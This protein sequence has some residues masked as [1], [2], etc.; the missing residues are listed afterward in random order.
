[1]ASADRVP[2]T[3][4]FAQTFSS[5]LATRLNDTVSMLTYLCSLSS[6]SISPL[7]ELDTVGRGARETEDRRG[8]QFLSPLKQKQ[9][10][11]TFVF[12]PCLCSNQLR[13]VSSSRDERL[14]L[15]FIDGNILKGNLPPA[16]TV[17]VRPS[18]FA[19]SRLYCDYGV[20]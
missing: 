19:C 20:S 12:S 14:Y 16:S 13:G 17:N 11:A 6:F 1:M 2:V 8:T 10:H 4:A 15:S 5:P 3:P 18:G 7:Q 9:R